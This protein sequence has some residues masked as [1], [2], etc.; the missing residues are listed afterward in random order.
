MKAK[1]ALFFLPLFAGACASANL[2]VIQVGP[3]FGARPWREVE[4]FSSREE[5]RSPW[6]AIGVIHSPP[7]KAADGGPEVARLKARA[8]RAAAAMGADGVIVTVDSAVAGPQLGVYQ[9]PEIFV[10]ALAI[11]YVTAVSTPAAK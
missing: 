8:R 7:V 11:K 9:E 1:A 5:T 4:V 10:S 6:G 3:W 2:D